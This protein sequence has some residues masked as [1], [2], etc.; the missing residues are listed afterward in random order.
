M[1]SII[2]TEQADADL[3]ATVAEH[4]TAQPGREHTARQIQTLV[5]VPCPIGRITAALDTL[6]RNGRIHRRKTKR[7]R[8]YQAKT[9][10]HRP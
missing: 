9:A 6:Y 8:L 7:G 2:R 10:G 5:S 1:P 4:L 3:R